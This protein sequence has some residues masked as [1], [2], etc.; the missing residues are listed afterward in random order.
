MPMQSRTT[1]LL[2]TDQQQSV[3]KTLYASETRSIAYTP[4][5]HRPPG[6]GSCSVLGFNGELPDPLTGHYHLG[7]GYRQF[8][9]VLMRF[10]SPDSW[11]PFGEGGLNTYVYCGGDPVNLTDPTGHIVFTVIKAVIKFRRLLSKNMPRIGQ[12]INSSNSVAALDLGGP[13]SAARTAALTPQVLPTTNISTPPTASSA[14]VSQLQI[15]QHHANR[16]MAR[17]GGR[18]ETYYPEQAAMRIAIDQP[19]GYS[20]VD[21]VLPSYNEALLRI[22]PSDPNYTKATLNSLA[23]KLALLRGSP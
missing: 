7:K 13:S 9:P 6:C 12:P 19:P 23:N 3:L 16:L 2:A 5:G 10:N 11:S 1:M 8:N 4:Y 15:S 21:G 18:R 22:H 17:R 14:A 20:T